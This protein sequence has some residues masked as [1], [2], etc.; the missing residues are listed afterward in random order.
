MTEIE[1][2]AAL[3]GDAPA[4]TTYAQDIRRIEDIVGRI[5]NGC[6]IDEMLA[7]ASEA[8]DLLKRCREK[9]AKTGIAMESVLKELQTAKSE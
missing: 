4:Q 2:N 6:D 8:A 5:Q 7:L 3:R 9:L 1:E